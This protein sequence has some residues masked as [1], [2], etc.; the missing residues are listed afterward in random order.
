MGGI[1]Q[2]TEHVCVKGGR[3]HETVITDSILL[4][5]KDPA[6]LSSHADRRKDE[7]DG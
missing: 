7:E 2:Q 6:V 4:L 3:G 1:R 5:K